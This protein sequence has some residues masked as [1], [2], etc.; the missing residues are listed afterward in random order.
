MTILIKQLSS[1]QAEALMT[2]KWWQSANAHSI[3][4]FQI[5]QSQLCC[6]LNVYRQSIRYSN[7]LY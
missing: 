7:G 6:P 3:V 4:A 2:S 1:A 5:S